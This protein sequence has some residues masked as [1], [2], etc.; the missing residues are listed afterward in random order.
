MRAGNFKGSPQKKQKRYD[1]DKD[2]W[3]WKFESG[4]LVEKTHSRNLFEK[5]QQE[6]RRPM[7]RTD[8]DHQDL[9][10]NLNGMR[11]ITDQAPH[12]QSLVQ[13]D[14]SQNQQDLPVQG[15]GIQVE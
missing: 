5:N 2:K 12:P 6:L 1:L 15:D 13:I 3:Y 9:A 11:I 14:S 10:R 7:V 4:E 8:N